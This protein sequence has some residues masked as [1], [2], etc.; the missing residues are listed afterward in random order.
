MKRFRPRMAGSSFVT[1]TTP[2]T[3]LP[4]A[5][6]ERYAACSRRTPFRTAD[7]PR[8]IA[9]RRMPTSSRQRTGKHKERKLSGSTAATVVDV[10]VATMGPPGSG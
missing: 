9:P 2:A 8:L 7:R 1:W 3:A 6:D 5:L 4:I 10:D